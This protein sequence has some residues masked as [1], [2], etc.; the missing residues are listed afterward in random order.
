M[1]ESCFKGRFC[2]KGGF[3]LIE[4]LVVVLIIGIL[5]TVAVPQYQKATEKARF[6]QAVASMNALHKACEV[7][8]L[9]N[10]A[11]PTN[12]SQLDIDPNLPD[13][14]RVTLY[15]GIPSTTG[16]FAIDMYVKRDGENILEYVHYLQEDGKPSQDKECRVWEDKPVFH[17]LCRSISSQATGI[18]ETSY[19]AYEFK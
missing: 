17:Q 15:H 8:Y 7:Y 3:T 11:Y 4:L 13:G 6:V 9:A 16:F 10:G 2:S 1:K 18:E 14:Y 5:A 12:L 19:T